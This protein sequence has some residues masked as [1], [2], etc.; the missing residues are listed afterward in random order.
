MKL[1]KESIRGLSS[2]EIGKSLFGMNHTKNIT[3][4]KVGDYLDVTIKGEHRLVTVLD[5]NTTDGEGYAIV[6]NPDWEAG[7]PE[8]IIIEPKDILF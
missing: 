4:V 7:E 2:K 3:D 6:Q 8:A 1:V 5:V